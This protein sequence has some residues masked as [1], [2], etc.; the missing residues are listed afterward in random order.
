MDDMF[1]KKSSKTSKRPKLTKEDRLKRA[2]KTNMQRR[3][4][5]S[6]VRSS[7]QETSLDGKSK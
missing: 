4:I 7:Q 2:L 5:Q 1:E 3:K 6:R